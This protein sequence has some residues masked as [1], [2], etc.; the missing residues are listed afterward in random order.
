MTTIMPKRRKDKVDEL[1][2]AAGT[3]LTAQAFKRMRRS[4]VAITG[5]VIVAL[6]LLMAIFAPLLTPKDP[7]F[8]YPEL[9]TIKT[10]NFI[11]GSMPGFLFGSD[12]FGRDFFSR[13]LVASQQTL[14]VGVLATLI[15]LSIGM[16]IGGLAGAFGGWVD[17]VLMRL[18]DVMLSVPSLLLAISIAALAAQPSQWTVIIAV[19]IVTVPIFARLLRGAMLAQ[20]SSDH[21]LAATAV[22]IRR[23]TIVLRHMLPNS[24]GPV[25]VQATLT[26]ATAILEAAALSFLGLGD[27]DTDRAEWGLMLANAQRYLEVRPELAFYPAIA[28]IIVAL[29]FTLLGESMREALDPKNRR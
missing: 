28:I 8:R 14:L 17:T 5:A 26:L 4:P 25:L 10:P 15:G 29:G 7:Y 16:V 19:S 23:R 27:P 20:R 18:V 13:V 12:E 11:P 3:S 21:V 22:G 2:K 24:M 6:F 1:A 9:F